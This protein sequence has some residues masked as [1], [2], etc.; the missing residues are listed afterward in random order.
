MLSS[1]RNNK[2]LGEQHH[3]PLNLLTAKKQKSLPYNARNMATAQASNEHER[4]KFANNMMPVSEQVP[5]GPNYT[6]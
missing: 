6:A 2:T 1:V 5:S 4:K 3:E